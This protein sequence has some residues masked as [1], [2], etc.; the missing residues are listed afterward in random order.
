MSDAVR[1]RIRPLDPHAHLFEV[2]CTV[3]QPDAAGQRFRLPTWVPG[4]YLVR[5]FARHFV[6]VTAQDARGDLAL[7]KEAKDLWRA[8]PSP[9]PITVTAHVY[10]FD[11]SVRAAY[12]DRTRGF[13][14]GTAVF[15]CPEG[16][17]Q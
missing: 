17:E 12:L 2:Q 6:R 4:S 7:V 9:G 3:A 8:A 13:F 14:N 16:F 11:L 1:Y 10:A 5:E 15:L